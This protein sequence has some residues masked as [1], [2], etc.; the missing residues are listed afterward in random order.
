MDQNQI[1]TF[2]ATYDHIKDRTLVI[3]DFSNVEKWR[4]SL[5]WKVGIQ[6]LASLIKH[7]TYGNRSLR[8][9]YY[10]SD[11]GPDDRSSEMVPWSKG[12]ITKAQYNK[13][14]VVTKRVKY[15][16]NNGEQDVKKCDLD[17]EMAVDLI[18]LRDEYDQ[19]IVFSGDGDL[20]YAMKYLHENFGKSFVVFAARNHVSRE[21]I[22]FSKTD[23]ITRI[24]FAE[25]F[26]YRIRG[27]RI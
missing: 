26:E 15:I 1:R 4:E 8:R 16:K 27:R 7:F 17:V 21:V 10:G 14:E 3:V 22:D 13:L 24:L 18:K 11:Y 23:V 12:L 2:L 20:T 5:S 6:E 25:D 19:A 9:F